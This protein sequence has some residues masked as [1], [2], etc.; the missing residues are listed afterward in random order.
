MQFTDSHF[1]LT[2]KVAI[3]TGALG[4]IGKE[5]CRAL[6]HAGATVI[7][8]DL[9]GEACISFAETLPGKAMGYGADITNPDSVRS[10]R[11]FVLSECGTIDVLVNNAAI[12]DKFESPLAAL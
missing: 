4:L 3:V 5:Y 11:D 9:D 1:S 7:A 10:L 12:N 2:G 8:T 6:A